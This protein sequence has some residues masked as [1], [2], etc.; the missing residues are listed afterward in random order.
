MTPGMSAVRRNADIKRLDMAIR[1]SQIVWGSFCRLEL[2]CCFYK[3]LHSATDSNQ[4]VIT[5]A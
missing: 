2:E 1:S 4:L 5:C 3:D